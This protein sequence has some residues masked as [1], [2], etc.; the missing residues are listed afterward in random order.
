MKCKT[1]GREP[2]RSNEVN[3]RYWA[4]LALVS[5]KLKPQGVQYSRD[6]WHT[7]MK[8]KFLGAKEVWLPN[9]TMRVYSESTSSMDKGEFSEYL[10]KV[11]AWCG[12]HN[13]WLDE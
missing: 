11:Q 9:G 1:C 4:L 7:Y 10:D 3:K 6:S 8:E 13:V 5:E 2:R 12:E